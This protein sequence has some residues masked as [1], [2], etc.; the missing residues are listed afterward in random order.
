MARTERHKIHNREAV[1]EMPEWM[2]EKNLAKNGLH[3]EIYLSDFRKTVPSKLKT[4]LREPVKWQHPPMPD[5]SIPNATIHFRRRI[6]Y[7]LKGYLFLKVS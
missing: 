6:N 4:I 7:L 3:H 2:K 5:A 1:A